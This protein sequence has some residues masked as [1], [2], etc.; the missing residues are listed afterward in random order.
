MLVTVFAVM[1]LPVTAYAD[2]GPKPSVV[3][4][5]ENMSDEPCYGTLLSFV[6]SNGPYSAWERKD[7]YSE[8]TDHMLIALAEYV[9][10]DGYYFMGEIWNVGKDKEIE[11]GYY[12]PDYF[13]ILL[14][15]PESDTYAVSKELSRYAFDSYYSVDMSDGIDSVARIEAEKDYDYAAEIFALCIRVALTLLVEIAIAKMFGYWEKKQLAC[16]AI[17]NLATQIT[18]NVFLNV[19]A[20]SNGNGFDKGLAV[21]GLYVIGELLAL[22]IEAVV[23]I[24]WLDRLT[25]EPRKRG[26]AIVHATLYA[27]VANIVSFV[28][29]L[30]LFDALPGIF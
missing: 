21:I 24:I 16:I 9:D 12:P 23:Y 10:E 25:K 29:G 19:S 2:M 30:Y 26:Y 18:L 14:Y 8:N 27:L 20:H 6:K 13:K 15:F 11:W 17:A 3:I 7:E 22:L 5:F 1:I 28:L 4:I